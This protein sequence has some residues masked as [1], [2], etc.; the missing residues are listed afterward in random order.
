MRVSDMRDM[1]NSDLR[2]ALLD[3]EKEY[4]GLLWDKGR[5][6]LRNVAKLRKGRCLIAEINTVLSERSVGGMSSNG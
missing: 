1:T 4:L 5:R 2:M 3:K 6:N